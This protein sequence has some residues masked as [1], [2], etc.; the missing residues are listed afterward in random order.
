MTHELVHQS[1]AAIHNQH[2][3]KTIGEAVPLAKRRRHQRHRSAA[4]QQKQS[5]A[6]A[7]GAISTQ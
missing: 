7:S 1:T 6:L 3:T 2:S 4:S 5:L